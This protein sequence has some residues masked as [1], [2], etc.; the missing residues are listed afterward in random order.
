MHAGEGKPGEAQ[1]IKLRSEPGV[2]AVALLAGS[3]K[4]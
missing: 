3:G 4:T 2:H 1:V